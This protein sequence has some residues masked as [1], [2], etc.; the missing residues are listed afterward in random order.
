[1]D[2]EYQDLAPRY[3]HHAR[4]LVRCYQVIGSRGYLDVVECARKFG[5]CNSEQQ[6]SHCKGQ[7]QFY[8]GKALS[9]APA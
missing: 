8:E 9:H 5:Q 6:P 3:G 4:P 2:G 1:M 7:H